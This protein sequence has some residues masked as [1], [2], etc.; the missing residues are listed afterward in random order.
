MRVF[1]VLSATVVAL[2]LAGCGQSTSP[3]K[4]A[5]DANSSDCGTGPASG[6]RVRT[7]SFEFVAAAGPLEQT[8]TKAQ[9]AAQHPDAGETMI[10]GA[11]MDESGMPMTSGSGSGMSSQGPTGNDMGGTP[12]NPAV[13]GAFRHVEVH[14]CGRAS[15]RVVQNAAP[16]MTLTDTSGS[17]LTQKLPIAV[18]QGVHSGL[19][20]MHYGNNARMM[21][22]HHY[23]LD[24]TMRGE[25]AKFDL[26]SAQ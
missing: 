7:A 9:V 3:G 13:S 21:R 20:D 15:G 1:P 22:G 24:V 16:A 18:M 14:I 8:Y 17:G 6:H 10:S 23:S 2:V 26:G 25:H 5:T 11:M 19:A 12:V 4:A